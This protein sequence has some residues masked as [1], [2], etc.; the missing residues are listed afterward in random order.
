MFVSHVGGTSLRT[1]GDRGRWDGV[2]GD[3][4][5]GILSHS[6]LYSQEGKETFS[7]LTPAIVTLCARAWGEATVD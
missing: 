7:T 4:S 3:L 1:S 2:T 6:I 5:W